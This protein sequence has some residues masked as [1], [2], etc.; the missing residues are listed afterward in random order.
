MARDVIYA[1]PLLKIIAFSQSKCSYSSV[2][3]II[4]TGLRTQVS[5]QEKV[6]FEISDNKGCASFLTK[7]L[8][9]QLKTVTYQR[10]ELLSKVEVFD[11]QLKAAAEEREAVDKE[12]KD[13]KDE[14][15][16]VKNQL[17]QLKEN[18]QIEQREKEVMQ[19]LY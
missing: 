13:S 18:L 14:F 10:D 12:F 5:S 4:P 16:S 8:Q 19:N 6:Q 3:C 9:E 11:K 7:E 2:H 17:L 1:C 15:Q